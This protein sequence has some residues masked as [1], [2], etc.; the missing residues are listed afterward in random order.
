MMLLHVADQ[1]ALVLSSW[2]AALVRKAD[3]R[4]SNGE[5]STGFYDSPREQKQIAI[6][7]S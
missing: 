6:R 2:L 4:S 3:E 1:R 7:A 5:G